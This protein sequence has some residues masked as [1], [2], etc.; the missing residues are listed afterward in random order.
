MKVAF[1]AS[2]VFPFAKTGGLGDVCGSLP[3]ALEKVG[4]EISI[5]MPGYRSI[6]QAGYAIHQ[7]NERVS[8]ATLGSGINVYFIEHKG[9]FDRSGFYGDGAKDYPDNLD[10]FSFLCDQILAL[11]KQLDFQPDIVHCH[12]WQ[13][14]LIPV[15]IK[16]KY[17][18][19]QFYSKLKSLLTIHNLAFQGMF[20]E[21]EYNKL[22]LDR[23]LFG[24]HGFQF[25][26]Q[27][28]LLKAG[29]IYS[30]IV[31]TVSPQYAKEIR[32]A[33]F[34]CGLD[35]VLRGRKGRVE[36]I[37]NG[38]DDKIWNPQTDGFI[39]QKY[40]QD[41][42]KE[43]KSINKTQ[44]QK[45][46]HLEVNED[47]PLFGFVGRLSKQK[48]MDLILEAMEGLINMNVQMVFLGKG[49][50]RYQN[51]LSRL[52]ARYSEKISAS[53]DFNEPLGHRIY[54]GSDFFLMPSEYEPCGLS[55]MISLTYGTIPIVSHTGGLVDT[56]KPFNFINRDGNGFVFNQHT[57]AALMDEIKK[58]LNVYQHKDQFD[59]LRVNT[60]CSE[61]SWDKSAQKYQEIYRSGELS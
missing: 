35:E 19:D 44:L 38:I 48:G 7:V 24:P 49:E 34:G 16:E 53:F 1:C 52:A 10:R 51:Q 47:I 61:F 33:Q 20:P 25:H 4:V 57:P 58:T 23:R 29:I 59:R 39:A 12:E 15:Y 17:R 50:D 8:R 2:E 18:N 54:A 5:F 56:V 60:F 37:L 42:F 31:T 27:V 30:D 45:E 9:Y 36:G 46:L 14:A 21:G 6:G 3:L 13:T 43:A 28:N 32:T 11:F 55:Q 41:N 40:S 26:G 22:G